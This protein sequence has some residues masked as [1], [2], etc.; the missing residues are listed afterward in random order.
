MPARGLEV[1]VGTPL[2]WGVSILLGVTAAR[3]TRCIAVRFQ[4][5]GRMLEQN[6]V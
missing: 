1:P 6:T 2:A 3:I 4:V 5:D